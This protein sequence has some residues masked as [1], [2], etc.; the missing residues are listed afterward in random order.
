MRGGFLKRIIEEMSD[1]VDGHHDMVSSVESID[2][3]S[4]NHWRVRIRGP[5]NTPYEH[6]VFELKVTFGDNYP[7]QPPKCIFKT[8]IWHPNIFD[9][10]GS[11]DSP[12]LA[13]RYQ[14]YICVVR[15]F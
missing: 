10:Q 4:F 15:Q 8:R 9:I 3:D 11:P 14:G 12:E 13:K 7:V 5:E 2:E 6:G 1:L